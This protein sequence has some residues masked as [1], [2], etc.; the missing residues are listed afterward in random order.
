MLK[1]LSIR[2]LKFFLAGHGMSGRM[3]KYFLLAVLVGV[4][5]GFVTVGFYWMIGLAKTLVETGCAHAFVSTLST[6]QP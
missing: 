4:L 1:Q 3:G 5:T 2:V 6:P